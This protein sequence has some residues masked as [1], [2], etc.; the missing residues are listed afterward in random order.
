MN[1]V[2]MVKEFQCPGC[3][4]GYSPDTCGSY[5]LWSEY[6]ERCQNHVLGTTVNF[7][8][9]F[10]LG[11]PKGFNRPTLDLHEGLPAKRCNSVME[12]RLW[13]QNTAPRWNKF[14]VAVWAMER[15]GYLFVRTVSPRTAR[16]FTDVI[17]G[18][19]LSMCP[20]AVNVG[21]FYDDID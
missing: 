18:G 17:E 15:D 5:S 6:G 8:I 19:T 9:S 2:D 7:S 16:I 4:N 13:T 14:N 1:I 11:L 21:E 12:I 20:G 10:A 3:V